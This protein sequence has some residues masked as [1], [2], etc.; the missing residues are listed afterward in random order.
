MGYAQRFA[1]SQTSPHRSPGRRSGGAVWVGGGSASNN[2]TRK[3]G[4][5]DAG[6][7]DAQVCACACTCRTL[8][9]MRYLCCTS[10]NACVSP[11]RSCL[12]SQPFKKYQQVLQLAQLLHTMQ[13]QTAASEAASTAAMASMAQQLRT[14]AAQQEAAQATLADLTGR[15]QQ[16]E[17]G[18]AGLQA[19][20]QVRWCLA[21]VGCRRSGGS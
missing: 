14:L 20:T 3:A 15:L 18:Q 17:G 1:N 12:T 7:V 21:V 6:A 11:F 13:Q 2:N 9:L 4:A 5:C 19:V 8:H 16:L 10:G